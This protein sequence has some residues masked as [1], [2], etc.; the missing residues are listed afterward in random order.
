MNQGFKILLNGVH[1]CLGLFCVRSETCK[2][3]C[4]L[5]EDRIL[6]R[7]LDIMFCEAASS[8]LGCLWSSQPFLI[9]FS[10]A[11]PGMLGHA[12]ASETG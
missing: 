2:I 6:G 3:S 9:R 4:L 8:T 11:T 10:A 7:G 5:M 1:S 12:N